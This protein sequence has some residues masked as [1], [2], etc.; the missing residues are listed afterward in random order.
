MKVGVNREYALR[1]LFFVVLMLGVA[2]WF[3]YDGY[4]GYPQMPAAALYESIEKAPPPAQ[5]TEAQLDAFKAQKVGFQR[6]LAL[7]ALLGGAFVGL[8]LLASARFS[9]AYDAEGFTYRGRRYAYADVKAV[10][11]SAWEAKRIARVRLADGAR[12][13]LDAW[14]HVGVKEFYEKIKT[15]VDTTAK[16]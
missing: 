1:H 3:A 4:V 5:M 6:A 10:D 15:P 11:A 13:T 12:L 14:H 16:I 8:R 2:G 7:A 9:L